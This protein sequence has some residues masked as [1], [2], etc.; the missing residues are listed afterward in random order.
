VV[1]F[2]LE[3]GEGGEAGSDAVARAKGK[4]QDKRLDYVIL[5]DAREPGAGFE[6]ATNRVTIL[7]RNGF[8]QALPLLPKRDVA[9]QILDVVE[10]G[11]T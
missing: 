11:L 1:G 8:E 6:V 5:N 3:A 2:A 7:G 4:L 9:E 10:H